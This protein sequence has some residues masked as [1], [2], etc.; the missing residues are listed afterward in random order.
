M[1][2]RPSDAE[3]ATFSESPSSISTA[4]LLQHSGSIRYSPDRETLSLGYMCFGGNVRPVRTARYAWHHVL[5]AS[6]DD[7]APAQ[8]CAVSRCTF[9]TQRCVPQ[10]DKV[11]DIGMSFLPLLNVAH[12]RAC[13][14]R[15]R[16]SRMTSY[17]S[18]DAADLSSFKS[19]VPGRQTFFKCSTGLGGRVC[20]GITFS[21]LLNN[22][23]HVRKLT[24]KRGT[25]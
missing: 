11:C 23:S 17:S 1:E 12:P 24:Y 14:Y 2:V 15:S 5:L 18:R 9:S 13:T 16:S 8:D 7:G 21:D 4:T 3:D 20:R 19:R 22:S 6:H 25:T 10:T